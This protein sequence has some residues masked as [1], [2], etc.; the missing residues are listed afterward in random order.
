MKSHIVRAMI[1]KTYK[2]IFLF[3]DSVFFYDKYVLCFCT[4]LDYLTKPWQKLYKKRVF[5]EY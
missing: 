5:L 2:S 1:G 4:A 3:D